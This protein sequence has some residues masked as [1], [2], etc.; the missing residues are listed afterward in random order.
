MWDQKERDAVCYVQQVKHAFSF[1]SLLC[2]E[3]NQSLPLYVTIAWQSFAFCIT[4][5]AK[6]TFSC[7]WNINV[8]PWRHKRTARLFFPCSILKKPVKKKVM[9]CGHLV[10][11]V[12]R[13]PRWNSRTILSLMG[14]VTLHS[15]IHLKLKLWWDLD[16]LSE[17]RLQNWS[18]KFCH[19]YVILV[20]VYL[21]PFAC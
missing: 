2:I 14:S 11:Y 16:R 1:L 5:Y 4:Y 19:F 15:R 10:P 8:C 3:W 12:I 17:T 7:I 18:C 20:A 21:A 13:V 9:N 6:C